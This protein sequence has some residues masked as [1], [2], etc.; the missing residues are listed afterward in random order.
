MDKYIIQDTGGCRKAF[1]FGE[2]KVAK[3]LLNELA[4]FTVGDVAADMRCSPDNVRR[5]ER[6]GVL[7]AAVKTRRGIR[8]FRVSDVEK[9]K[10]ERAA[11]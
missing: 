10:R 5:L 11:K 3:K 9:L 2:V 4:L 6:E 7:P 1:V 8:L